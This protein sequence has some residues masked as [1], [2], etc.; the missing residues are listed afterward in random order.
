MKL[1]VDKLDFDHCEDEQI[2]IPESIQSYG[3]LFALNPNDHTIEII[4]ENVLDLFHDGQPILHSNFLDLLDE[5]DDGLAFFA[6]TYGRARSRNTRLPVK[7]KF[8]RSLIKAEN[9]SSYFAVVYS[10]D[11]RIVIELEPTAKFREAYTADHYIKI[12]AMSI[13]PKFKSF[14]SLDEMAREIVETIRYVTGMERVALYKF[15]D[16]ESGKVIAESKVE[17]IESYLNLYYPASD[18]PSQ[19]RELYKKNWVRL[20]PNV[21]LEPAKLIPT[22]A[23]SS[24]AP[25]D[26]TQS[27]LRTFSPIHRQYIRNQGLLASFSMSLVTHD[28]LWGLI[29]CH[30][31]HATYIPQD[32]RLQ[33]ENLSQLFSWHLYA[34]EE[35][36]HF[37]QKENADKSIE[38]MLDKVSPKTPIVK[39]FSDHEEEVL[40]LMNADGFI[41]FSDQEVIRLGN[42]PS[43]N[44]I[45]HIYDRTDKMQ[46]R[47]FVTH[48]LGDEWASSEDLNNTAGVL[49]I[50][51]IEKRGYFTAWFRK[52]KPYTQKWA[53]EANEKSMSSSKRERL[54][55]RSS[56]TVHTREITGECPKFDKN[57]V[58]M[59]GRFNRMFLAHALET[60]EKLRKNMDDLERQDRHKNEFLATLA[61]ELRNPLA[62][63]SS[64]VSLMELSDDPRVRHKVIGTIKRQ[65]DYMTKLIDDLMD[66]SRITQGKIKLDIQKVSLQNTIFN[67]VE[68]IE[69]FIKDK[70]LELTLDL[71]ETTLYVQ[72]DSAR[73]SQIFSNILNNAIKYTNRGGHIAIALTSHRDEATVSIKDDGLG[74]PAHKLKDIF[75]MFTQV[76]AH[77]THTK[78]G[79]GIGL[80]LV[81]RLVT[82]HHGKVHA[83]SEGTDKG[84]EFIVIL[85]LSL[86]A[87]T[88]AVAAE[89]SQVVE[90][91]LRVLIV[92][93]NT[94]V[95][96]LLELLLQNEGHD[97]RSASHGR[98]AIEIFKDFV[99][100]VA[101]LDIGMPDIDGYE[102]CTILKGLPNSDATIFF[103]QSGWGNKEYVERALEVGFDRHF[104]KPLNFND[105][106][107]AL[108]KNFSRED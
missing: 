25:L 58:D 45:Q 89:E 20:V 7:L 94:D 80:T 103:A 10:S 62:P 41:F 46:G 22:I 38:K 4:S 6:E 77:S 23:E 59:A 108:A 63:I 88:E 26:L 97:T 28:R 60:Q 33:C 93:D 96:S 30:S 95:L 1:D 39:V 57:D 106:K 55:P 29:T 81:E 13:A 51:F 101:I 2:H 56:F 99:P 48:R 61:H 85:P 92:D 78:G 12:Y 83:I 27:L 32:V 5:D 42:V 3:Y 18:I 8:D 53:G 86:Q 107:T 34:K 82:L 24:R 49:L 35:E 50:P 66:V 54:M 19:A 44:V 40:K 21:D 98:E 74:I 69:D 31:R 68:I 79:L 43:L 90:A 52:E 9:E 47:P 84:S 36:L 73:L 17:D 105:L 104:V 67:S 65:V 87:N 37:S 102:L 70:S 15:N 16:D 72:G 91:K 100:H 11:S 75:S 76:E 64:G 71:P 14:H